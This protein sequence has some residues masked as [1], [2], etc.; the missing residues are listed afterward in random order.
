VCVP[1][2]SPLTFCVPLVAALASDGPETDT[3][4]ALA[5]LHVIV[6]ENGAVP[7]EGLAAIVPETD[8]GDVTV[9]VAVSVV[10]P[11]GPCAVIA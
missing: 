7:V 4:V 8:A 3:E 10:G 11:P 9:T 2:A 6:V 1:A 5:V